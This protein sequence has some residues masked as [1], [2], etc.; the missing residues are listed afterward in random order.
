MVRQEL[1][2]LDRNLEM[3]RTLRRRCKRN[4]G[5]RRGTPQM[6]FVRTLSDT[7]TLLLLLNRDTEITMQDDC[8]FIDAPT[9]GLGR[10]ILGHTIENLA[11]DSWE[12]VLP[13]FMQSGGARVTEKPRRNL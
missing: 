4:L 12:R 2:F 11:F 9:G 6:T 8:L 1:M 13:A 7:R 10:I 5:I 3:L